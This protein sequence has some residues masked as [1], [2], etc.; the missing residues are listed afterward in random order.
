MGT[1]KDL[2]KT[3]EQKL[4]KG[5]TIN[6]RFDELSCQIFLQSPGKEFLHLLK[7]QFLYAEVANPQENAAVAY[8]REGQNS[9][10]RRILRSITQYKTESSAE[11][12]K[13]P[14]E[15]TTKN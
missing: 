1:F 2:D 10:V 3:L 9:L 15:E 8:F 4:N 11:S 13:I 14:V 7:E 12:N 6:N 5:I